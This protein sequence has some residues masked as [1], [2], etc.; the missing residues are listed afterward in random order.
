[1][2]NTLKDK[3]MSNHGALLDFVI[4]GTR[5]DMNVMAVLCWTLDRFLAFGGVE[6]RGSVIKQ[7]RRC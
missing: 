6:G 3:S 7:A 1:M 5:D 2:D 4:T